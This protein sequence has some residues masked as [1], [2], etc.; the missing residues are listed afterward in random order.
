MMLPADAQMAQG[1]SALPATWQTFLQTQSKNLSQAGL[2]RTIESLQSPPG[3]TAW[4]SGQELILLCS[5]NYL[6]L[7]TDPRLIA[8]ARHAAQEFGVGSGAS[9][10]LSGSSPLHAALE[11]RLSALPSDAAA[12]DRGGAGCLFFVAAPRCSCHTSQRGRAVIGSAARPWRAGVAFTRGAA[13][14]GGATRT[15]R[16][17]R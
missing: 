10:L 3:P 9:R 14:L 13:C 1:E 11:Q 12:G 7:A 6:G 8:A 17:S 2:W 4:M 5:N 16:L 15:E